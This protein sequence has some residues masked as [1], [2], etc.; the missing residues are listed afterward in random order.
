MKIHDHTVAKR[1]IE[2]VQIDTQSDP[3]SDSY[4]STSKQKNLSRKLYDEL[5]TMG[6][7]DVIL[8]EFNYLIARI[9]SNSKKDVPSI[10]FNAHV[11]TA[12]DCSGTNVKPIIHKSY[13]GNTILFPDDNSLKLDP[14]DHPNL[15]EK[16]GHDIIT[17]SGKTL[18]GADD[19]AGLA[20]IMDAAYQLINNQKIIHGDVFLLFTPDE[21]IGKGVAHLDISKMPA[22]FG[23]TL[24]G[25]NLGELNNENFS[26]DGAILTINGVT[27]HPG[28]AKDKMENA[29]K[30]AS[31]I[32]SALPKDR[33]CPETANEIDGFIHPTKIEGD[34]GTA[35]IHFILRN[36]DTSKLF[37]YGDL[38]QKIAKEVIANYPNS[39]FDYEQ[40]EQ[41]RNMN[42]VLSNKA[43]I[44]DL[45]IKATKAAGVMPHIK[46]I[47]GGTDGAVLT[48]LGLPCPNI[49]AGQQAIHSKLEWVSIQDMRKAVETVINICILNAV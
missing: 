41:Y 40:K 2:Y 27:T 3:Y 29:I 20:I 49:F 42:D 43:H 26:A 10:F 32:V 9:P 45:A 8:D 24:D 38:L 35:K 7:E 37:E 14:S 15:N 13:Q 46:K 28:Y 17:A 39:T 44:F 6:V 47:R 25:G 30:I 18:L 33:L 5:K 34:L 11:D 16:I 12:P 22:D 36:F 1:F 48:H 19:K 23:Y 21:E 4:P 31:E